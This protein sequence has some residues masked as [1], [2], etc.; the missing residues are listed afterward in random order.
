MPTLTSIVL[1]SA[2]ARLAAARS[3]VKSMTPPVLIVAP[4]RAA[5]DEFAIGLAADAGATFGITRSSVAE[6]VTRIALPELAQRGVT[7]SAP[8]SDE[9][10]SARI[11]DELMSRA[12]LRYFAPVARMPGFPRALARTLAELRQARIA[13]SSI[14][15][16][17]ANDD[18]AALLERA[19]AERQRASAVDYATMLE[20]ATRAVEE[21]TDAVA[22]RHLVLL[23]PVVSTDAERSEEHTV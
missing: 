17:P 23:D 7:P 11:T 1:P 12:A 13:P 6:L 5:A 20:T 4:T 8:I 14:A 16:G 18:I 10:V 9:A 21:G 3:H 2:A 22:G 15:G 19:T